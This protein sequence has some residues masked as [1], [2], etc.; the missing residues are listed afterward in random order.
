MICNCFPGLLQAPLQNAVHLDGLFLVVAEPRALLEARRAS[1]PKVHI[2][3]ENA[4]VGPRRGRLRQVGGD[5]GEGDGAAELDPAAAVVG[6][7]G[8]ADVPDADTV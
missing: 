8:Q 1:R 6:T 4:L 7:E 2:H 3:P 5:L